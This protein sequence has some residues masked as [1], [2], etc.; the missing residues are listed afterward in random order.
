MWYYLSI[1]QL[2]VAVNYV[3][4]LYRFSH[5]NQ[6]SN[7]QISQHYHQLKLDKLSSKRAKRHATS[8][9]SL[10]PAYNIIKIYYIGLMLDYSMGHRF[11]LIVTSCY[12]LF[13]Q[14]SRVSWVFESS[15]QSHDCKRPICLTVQPK[16][17]FLR[18]NLNLNCMTALI[19]P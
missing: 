6:K 12:R 10:K 18:P 9:R 1:Y 13:Y 2:T 4:L 7:T 15:R 19:N 8:R 11:N 14:L 17:D 5:F 3:L 16:Y